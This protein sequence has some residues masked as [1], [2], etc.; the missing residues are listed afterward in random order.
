MWLA[1]RPGARR[2]WRALLGLALLLGLMGGVVLTAAA[3]ARRTDTAFPR[4]LRR[5]HASAVLVTPARAAPPGPATTRYFAALARLPQV[6]KLTVT[7]Y[8]DMALAGPGGAPGPPVVAEASP[9]LLYT[10]DAADDRISV[11]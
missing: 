11:D 9:S 3:G 7:D 2:D 4:L 6:A 1:L 10:S 8:L 5:S